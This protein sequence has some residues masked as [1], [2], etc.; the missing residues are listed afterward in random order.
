MKVISSL[1][2][3]VFTVQPK[4]NRRAITSF[5][6]RKLAFLLLF[7][8]HFLGQLFTCVLA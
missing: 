2:T 1:L 5:C 7:A 8:A 6:A 3:I 4:N